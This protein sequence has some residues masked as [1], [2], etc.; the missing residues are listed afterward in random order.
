MCLYYIHIQPIYR[1]LLSLISKCLLVATLPV[2][3]LGCT[4][5]SMKPF[6]QFYCRENSSIYSLN[7]LILLVLTCSAA[8]VCLPSQKQGSSQDTVSTSQSLQRSKR[9]LFPCGDLQ[10]ATSHRIT[11]LSLS[12]SLAPTP[13]PL[14]LVG[15]SS[16]KTNRPQLREGLSTTVQCENIAV[17]QPTRTRANVFR[18]EIHALVWVIHLASRHSF[19]SSKYK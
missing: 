15:T 8:C 16:G 1:S 9:G 11:A 4:C 2:T 6:Q 18:R 14:Q 17:L 13:N 12:L 5:Y 19:I 7:S 10:Y 3:Q